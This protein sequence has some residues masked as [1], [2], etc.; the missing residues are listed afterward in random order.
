MVS[1]QRRQ[2]IDCNAFVLNYPGISLAEM[3]DVKLMNRT[4]TKFVT[5]LDRLECLLRMAE[6]RYYVQDI[7]GL[8]VIPYE[9]TYFD[10]PERAMY[11]AHHNRRLHRQKIRVRTYLDSGDTFLEIKTK[12]NHGRTKKK[13]VAMAHG[14]S[15]LEHEDFIRKRLWYYPED[16]SPTLKNHFNRITLVNMGKTERLTIDFGVRFHNCYNGKED[17]LE[18]LVII[19]L[20]RD[21]LQQSSILDMLRDLR[22]HPMGFSKYCMGMCMTDNGLKRNLFKEKLRRIDKISERKYD[23]AVGRR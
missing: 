23:C 11:L 13:R 3:A 6:G 15:I 8:H 20:K 10:T 22:I 12:N 16:L 18:N 1:R 4:D 9:T 14:E 17:E 7:G 19:E 2:M 21:G 5:V